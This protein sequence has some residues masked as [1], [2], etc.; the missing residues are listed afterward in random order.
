ML[1][2]KS[3][4]LSSYITLAIIPRF[5]WLSPT[6]W[7]KLIEVGAPFLRNRPFLCKFGEEVAS[8]EY[9]ENLIKEPSFSSPEVL[10]VILS[11]Q[12]FF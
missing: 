12:C 5:P 1:K 8:P 9:P 3:F 4:E 11:T 10:K 6:T 7:S 2:K